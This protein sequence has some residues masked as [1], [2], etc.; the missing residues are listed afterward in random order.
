[1][2][3]PRAVAIVP[4]EDLLQTLVESDRRFTLH[5]VVFDLYSAVFPARVRQLV[6]SAVFCGGVGE[7]QARLTLTAPSG[8]VVSNAPFT[9]TART[10]HI[11]AV[12]L[13]GA[14]LPEA[15]EY[16]LAVEL[17]GQT[18]LTAPL[19]VADLNRPSPDLP[20][21]AEAR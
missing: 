21:G 7:Y 17:E 4:A 20:A 13:S 15:G 2:T 12:N 14:V 1:M 5:R 8:A 11:Q 3:A 19:V 10:Y 9:F 18:A 16:T 6:V